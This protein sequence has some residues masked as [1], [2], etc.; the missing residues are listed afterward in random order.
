MP[1]DS[2]SICRKSVYR[3]LFTC[4]LLYIHRFA[5]IYTWEST[6]HKPVLPMNS[7]GWPRAS[8]S[9]MWLSICVCMFAQSM[10]FSINN[11]N[12]LSALL[13]SN[14]P[15]PRPSSFL[16]RLGCNLISPQVSISSNLVLNDPSAPHSHGTHISQNLFYSKDIYFFTWITTLW[17][18]PFTVYHSYWNMNTAHHFTFLPLFTHINKRNHFKQHGQN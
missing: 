16:S 8:C 10:F 6:V 7:C 18:P 1:L 17:F 9:K 11:C 2:V 14:L 5:C 15:S 12:L 4:R 13:V 3:L